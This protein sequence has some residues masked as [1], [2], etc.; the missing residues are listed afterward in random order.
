L[1]EETNGP[2][3]PETLLFQGN[4]ATLL[5]SKG[6]FQE[7]ERLCNCVL[8]GR[9]EVL[10]P[11]HPDTLT[12]LNE[13]GLLQQGMGNHAAAETH[14]RRAL[15]LQ[16]QLKGPKHTD[17]LI[18]V[19]NLACLFQVSGKARDAEPLCRRIF[20]VSEELLG[21]SHLDTVMAASRLGMLLLYDIGQPQEAE[22]LLRTSLHGMDD[23]LGPSHEQTRTTRRAY[24]DLMK[25]KDLLKKKVKQGFVE[26]ETK[27]LFIV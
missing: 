14:L 4:L 9:M 22:E 3:D 12:A 10:G 20:Q 25:Q 15:D 6:T 26:I 27:G 8:E 24:S 21:V 1:L 19:N 23:Q 16:E 18:I 7:A 13:L 2:T 11:T 17:T 5:I